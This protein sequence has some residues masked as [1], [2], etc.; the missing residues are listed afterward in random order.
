MIKLTLDAVQTSCGHGVPLY[1]YA[2]DRETLLTWAERKGKTGLEQYW[3]DKNQTSID[4]LP[5]HLLA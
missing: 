5:T 1:D 4:G 2:G 3:K